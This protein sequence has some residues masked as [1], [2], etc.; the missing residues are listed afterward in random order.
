MKTSQDIHTNVSRHLNQ[1]SK[2]SYIKCLKTFTP[3]SQDTYP[4]VSRRGVSRRLETLHVDLHYKPPCL[5]APQD[6]LRHGEYPNVLRRVLRHPTQGAL[7]RLKAPWDVS[8]HFSHWQCIWPC[9]LYSAWRW[10]QCHICDDKHTLHHASNTGNLRRR[11][12]SSRGEM[13]RGFPLYWREISTRR[14]WHHDRKMHWFNQ[15]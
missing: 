12:L 10:R 3:V 6:A 8:R 7:R 15:G 11:T 1:L 14:T 2:D 13:W 9:W 5:K 4:S